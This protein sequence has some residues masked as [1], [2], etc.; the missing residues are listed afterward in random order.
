MNPAKLTPKLAAQLEKTGPAEILELVLEV[1]PKFHSTETAN[2]RSRSERIAVQKAAFDRA[3][4]PIEEAVQKLGGEVTGQAWINQTVRA[5]V[6]A[7]EVGR[8]SDLEMIASI[9]TPHRL[10]LETR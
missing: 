3:I 7:R 5:R 10:E 1:D 9:D 2:S 4:A 6:P 8:L